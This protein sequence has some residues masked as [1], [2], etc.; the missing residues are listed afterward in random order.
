MQLLRSRSDGCLTSIIVGSDDKSP[1]H[2]F[3]AQAREVVKENTF[4]WI[5]WLSLD[6]VVLPW[7]ENWTVPALVRRGCVTGSV[8]WS[9]L[10]ASC[11]LPGRFCRSPSSD[12]AQQQSGRSPVFCLLD[13]TVKHKDLLK[14]MALCASKYSQD[15]HQQ[16][17]QKASKN[18]IMYN[19]SDVALWCYKCM[20]GC[21]GWMPGW[22]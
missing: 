11:V 14:I 18:L 4:I 9:C 6:P 10:G 13:G 7:S 22:G 21:D 2:F 17:P 3:D 19:M 15:L 8:P 20:D 12:F 16:S 5:R 1:I